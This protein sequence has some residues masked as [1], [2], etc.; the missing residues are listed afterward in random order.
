MQMT[1][2]LVH[3]S[4]CKNFYWT[5]KKTNSF[6]WKYLN[7][8]FFVFLKKIQMPK[9]QKHYF[10]LKPKKYIVVF[11]FTN[12]F[13]ELSFEN[14]CTPFCQKTRTSVQ[15]EVLQ[16]FFSLLIE[17]FCLFFL[18]FQLYNRDMVVSKIN[19]FFPIL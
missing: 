15:K 11:V 1:T 18:T 4:I 2:L 13:S 6:V 10:C 3:I 8:T 17:G 5:K 14:F 19:E 7:S 16:N 12:A 9:R